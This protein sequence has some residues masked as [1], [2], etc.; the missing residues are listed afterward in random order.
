MLSLR[1]QWQ[2]IHG[3]RL[4]MI[5]LAWASQRVLSRWMEY[6]REVPAGFASGCEYVPAFTRRRKGTSCHFAM[7]TG[8]AKTAYAVPASFADSRH[9]SC[10]SRR[11]SR[12]PRP[13]RPLPPSPPR[14]PN[15]PSSSPGQLIALPP[16]L[17]EPVQSASHPRSG[18][19][20]W[21]Y[22]SIPQCRER[23]TSTPAATCDGE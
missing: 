17:L 11:R 7:E 9:S 13:S 16:P 2:R 5:R 22:C 1:S 3:Q 8:R 23:S 6:A 21:A 14:Q 12:L 10:A 18:H 19:W 4:Y 20:F 15:P